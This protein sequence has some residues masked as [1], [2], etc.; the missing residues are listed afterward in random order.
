[1]TQQ[2]ISENVTDTAD[3]VVRGVQPDDSKS[4]AQSAFDKTQRTSDNEAHGGAAS[5][6]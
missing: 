3:R 2:K 5:S 4:G 1:L 6:M